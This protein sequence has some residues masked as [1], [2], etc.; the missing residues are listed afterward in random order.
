MKMQLYKLRIII[1]SIFL[2][3]ACSDEFID[4]DTINETQQIN[5]LSQQEIDDGWQLLF[6]GESTEH[7]RSYNSDSF[8]E[9]GWSVQDGSLFFEPEEMDGAEGGQNIITTEKFE[10]F[11]LKLEWKI[12]EGSNSGIFYGVLEQEEIDIYWSGMEYQIIDNNIF[13]EITPQSAKRLSGSLYDLVPAEPQ[14]MHPVGEWNTT[15]IIIDNSN[16]IHRQNGVTVVELERWTPEW[17]EMIRNSKFESHNEFGNIRNGH[18]GIQDHGGP[19]MVR[20]I[21]IKN[22]N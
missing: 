14:N 16:I 21:K 8:P 12:E 20:N 4:N 2:L 5:V 1:I 10:N 15:E 6:D 3:A 9:I 17:F 7:W 13:S 22:L 19:V 11:H 18:I